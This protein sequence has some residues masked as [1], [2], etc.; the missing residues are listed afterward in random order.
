[1]YSSPGGFLMASTAALRLSGDA[2]SKSPIMSGSI[3]AKKVISEDFIDETREDELSGDVTLEVEAQEE[4]IIVKRNSGIVT[5]WA[6]FSIVGKIAKL[7][8]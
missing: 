7:L 2:I 8:S 4:I 1:M 6:I 3:D 5:K